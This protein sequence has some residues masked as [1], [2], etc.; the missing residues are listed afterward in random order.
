ML[1][2]G[3]KLVKHRDPYAGSLRYHLGL[4]TP[5]SEDC[6]IDV[7]GK[8]YWWKDGEA[9]MFDETF[10]HYANNESEKNRI[11]LFIDVKRPVTFFLV[12]WI[13][14]LFSKVILS[15]TA[16]KNTE[17]DKVGL[18]NRVFPYI[19]SIRKLGKKIKTFNKKLYYLL[20]YSIYAAIIYAIVS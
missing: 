9:V 14:T 13:N 19:Y 17:D 4:V 1:P 12:D 16:T 8:K 20:Q 10:I 18:L 15:A 7:D 11:V 6:Y 3:A 5:N 2:P